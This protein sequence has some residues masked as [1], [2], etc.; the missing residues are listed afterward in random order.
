MYA[1]PGRELPLL[2]VLEIPNDVRQHHLVISTSP[3]CMP[4]LTIF[5]TGHRQRG[6]EYGYHSY[7]VLGLEEVDRQPHPHRHRGAPHTWANHP[8]PFFPASPSPSTL[9]AFVASSKLSFVPVFRSPRRTLSAHGTT[10]TRHALL[11]PQSLPR[12]SAEVWP[13]LCVF[14]EAMSL[15]GPPLGQCSSGSVTSLIAGSIIVG[16]SR[17]MWSLPAL[18]ARKQGNNVR[19]CTCPFTCILL[20]RQRRRG[21]GPPAQ[22]TLVANIRQ[23][24]FTTVVLTEHTWSWIEMYREWSTNVPP[25]YRHEMT[26]L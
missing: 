22:N 23:N 1:T 16:W 12:V 24:A 14:L 25:T 11:H 18:G 13:A 6:Q 17:D 9:P 4:L 8:L 20:V 10:R 21:G 15:E 2:R 5:A 3:P 26:I 19:S 7:V